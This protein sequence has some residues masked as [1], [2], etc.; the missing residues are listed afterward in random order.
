MADQTM[1]TAIDGAM[2]AEAFPVQ[3][4]TTALLAGSEAAD[5]LYPRQW[6][7]RF[8]VQVQGTTVL[9]PARLHFASEQPALRPGVEAW[10][11][12]RALQTRSNDGFERQ[13]AVRDLLTELE[14]WAAPFVLTLIGE[15]VVEIIEDIA[16]SLNPRSERMLCHIIA[17]NQELW[18]VIKQRVASYWNVYY[19]AR[20][21]EGR[22]E[23][24][25]E[26]VGFRLVQ[27]LDAAGS[28]FAIATAE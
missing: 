22:A 15:Y 2:L 1:L 5:R 26:Y 12:A 23:R 24:R 14:L 27:Q 3:Y 25:D 8:I 4:R 13:R 9:I 11:L 21:R 16:S 6:T 18:G 19:R 20:W 7:E 28:R 17:D 10:Q